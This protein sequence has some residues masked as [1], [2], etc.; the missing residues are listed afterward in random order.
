MHRFKVLLVDDDIK[1]L[2]SMK[3]GL[4]HA[5]D[6]STAPTGVRAMELFRNERFDAAVLDIEMPMMMGLELMP[7]LKALRP[8]CRFLFLTCFTDDKIYL[9]S[10]ALGPDDFLTKPITPLRLEA[11]IRH[12]LLHETHALAPRFGTLT[13]DQENGHIEHGSE[14]IFLTRKEQQI[15]LALIQS[16]DHK[17]HRDYLMQRL[18]DGLSISSHTLNTHITNLRRKL[19]PTGVQIQIDKDRFVSLTETAR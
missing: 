11:A 14:R 7:H 2:A 4:D 13:L 3:A 12:R 5:F 1:L 19:G 15:F 18:W 10:L 8:E 6:V 16:A 17:V 9:E